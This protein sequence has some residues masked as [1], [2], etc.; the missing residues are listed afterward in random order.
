MAFSDIK[1]MTSGKSELI[2][3]TK[4]EQLRAYW[5]KLNK[6]RPPKK[7]STSQIKKEMKKNSN[8]I[9]YSKNDITGKLLLT[10]K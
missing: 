5:I 4:D 10:I 7:L 2:S 9:S 3:V 8:I 6:K 1:I